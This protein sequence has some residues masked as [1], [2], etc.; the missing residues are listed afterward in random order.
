MVLP[1]VPMPDFPPAPRD[2]APRESASVTLGE[3][4]R[5]APPKPGEV[6]VLTI[7][8]H[9]SPAQADGIRMAWREC[10][11]DAKLLIMGRGARLSV[12]TA[13]DGEAA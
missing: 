11:G 7:D 13:P 2:F 12:V 10:F 6:F 1:V 8:A 5:I 4:V 3:L 9:L